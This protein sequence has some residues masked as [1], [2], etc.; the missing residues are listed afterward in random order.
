MFVSYD[1]IAETTSDSTS[2]KADVVL[3]ESY[4]NCTFKIIK[5]VSG[6][7]IT[8]VIDATVYLERSDTSCLFSDEVKFNPVVAI[9]EINTLPYSAVLTTPRLESNEPFSPPNTC[10]DCAFA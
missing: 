8:G 3:L 10:T 2:L 9:I 6:S 5:V 1:V 4:L 7:I